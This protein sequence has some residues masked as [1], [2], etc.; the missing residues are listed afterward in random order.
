[1][2]KRMQNQ[3]A[4]KHVTLSPPRMLIE[5]ID[6]P[7]SKL[8]ARKPKY[9]NGNFNA[10]EPVNPRRQRITVGHSTQQ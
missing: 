9:H 7:A 8:S 6:P 4:S 3:T 1:M 10:L 5:S 2:M